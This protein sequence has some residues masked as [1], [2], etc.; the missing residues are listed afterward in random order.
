MTQGIYDAAATR[1]QDAPKA[2][3]WYPKN[4][5]KAVSAQRLQ[6]LAAAREVYDERL[7]FGLTKLAGPGGN[8]TAHVG[9]PDQ[10]A[11]ALLQYYDLGVTKFL[12]RGFDPLQDVIDWGK[13]LIPALHTGARA[14]SIGVS[15]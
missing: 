14:R 1:V 10:V 7:W 5:N 8:S 2:A 15:A 3:L 11:E 12:V 6:E 4:T 9:T 13:E